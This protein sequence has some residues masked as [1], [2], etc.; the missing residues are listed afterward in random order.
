MQFLPIVTA[1]SLPI[2]AQLIYIGLSILVGFLGRH[3]V[4][5]FWGTFFCSLVLSPIVGGLIVIVS[6]RKKA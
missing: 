3:R 2:Y 4:M 1:L 5:Q 6:A